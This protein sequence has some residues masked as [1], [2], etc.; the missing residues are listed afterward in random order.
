M[1]SLSPVVSGTNLLQRSLLVILLGAMA[2]LL[3]GACHPG[4]STAVLKGAPPAGYVDTKIGAGDELEIV[5]LGEDLPKQY[6][7]EPNG[8]ITFPYVQQVKVA[9]LTPPEAARLLAKKLGQGYFRN[10]QVHVYVKEYRSKRVT[11][12]GKV[13][14]PGVFSYTDN[15]NIIAAITEA[16]GFTDMADQNAT[17]ITRIVDGRKHRIRVRVKD[18][19]EGKIQNFMLRPGDVIFVP[20]RLF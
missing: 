5:L 14:K 1:A 15:M 18:I 17:T 4:P 13:K 19:G 3:P 10:P 11:V 6:R 16:G 9:G 20:K 12:F 8:S 7:V 2:D